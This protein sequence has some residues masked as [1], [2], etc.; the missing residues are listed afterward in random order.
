[1]KKGLTLI[2]V[3]ILSLALY[4]MYLEGY[5]D[6]D[7][8]VISITFILCSILNIG[9]LYNNK[10]ILLISSSLVE[11]ILVTIFIVINN[12]YNYLYFQSEELLPLLIQAVSG[13]VA[14]FFVENETKSKKKKN[15]IKGLSLTFGIVLIFILGTYLG[16]ILF[17]SVSNNSS[18]TI[19]N[20]KEDL[21]NPNII[22]ENKTT[23]NVN[24]NLVRS[25]MIY[26]H[27]IIQNR[28]YNSAYLGYFYNNRI[29][30]INDISDEIKVFMAIQYLKNNTWNEFD[31]IVL[32]EID[33]SS[34]INHIFGEITYNN[35]S[36][37]DDNCIYGDFTYDDKTKT[38]NH[39]KSECS[40]PDYPKYITKVTS[41]IKFDNRIEITE[42]ALYQTIIE[43]NN[44]KYI[45]L[46][47]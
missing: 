8:F 42:K 35:V 14:S 12:Y 30:D 44:N 21:I 10:K 46:K 2:S 37:Y 18:T 5:S 19:F 6:T 45:I 28:S 17:K 33:V 32:N 34:A 7:I 22:N 25:L 3:L 36:I 27:Y 43:D 1:M 40:I 11:L 26:P 41:A 24:D 31:N 9:L 23:L 16:Y 13:F 20:T 38:Y 29:Y 15:I 39:Y 47:R 4:I